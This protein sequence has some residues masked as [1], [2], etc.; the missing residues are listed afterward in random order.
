MWTSPVARSM[1]LVEAPRY[2]PIDSTAP[3]PTI[4]P[5]AT[6]ARAPMKA[7]SS[8]MTGPAC[9]GSSTPPMPAPPEICTPLPICAQEPTV[10]QASIIEPSPTYAPMLTK[11]G[12]STAPLAIC[13]PRRTMEPGTTRK[14]PARNS[15]S[16][17]P[18]NFSGTLSKAGAPAEPYSITA[19]SFRRKDSRTAF[20]SH[21]LTFHPPLP[22]GS[23]TRAAPESSRPSARSTL[24]RTSSLAG[25]TV[26]RTSKAA[27]MAAERCAM[28]GMCL[29]FP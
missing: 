13:A 8:M 10:A 20:F 11:L 12:S 26:S 5:S 23:A 25:V 17:Q 27:S 15:A 1:I 18:V 7:L 29:G 21:W 24:A 16:V 22:S 6:S 3:V 19:L 2:T 14:P 9:S 4:T 28:L